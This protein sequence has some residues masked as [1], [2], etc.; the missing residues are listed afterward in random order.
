M[1]AKE[2]EGQGGL[3]GKEGKERGHGI[4]SLIFQ[5]YMVREGGVLDGGGSEVLLEA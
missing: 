2:A 4:V 5:E 1:L 3:N